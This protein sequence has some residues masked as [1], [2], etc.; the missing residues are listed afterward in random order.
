MK[1][2]LLS[3]AFLLLLLYSSTPIIVEAQ[4]TNTLEW[5]VEVGEEFTYVMQRGYFI[6]PD[7]RIAFSEDN[8]FILSMIVGEKATLRVDGLGEIPTLINDSSQIPQSI[9]NL[10]RSND[11]VPINEDPLDL[12]FVIPIGDWDFLTEMTNLTG[13]QDVTLVDTADEWGTSGVGSFLAPDQSVV[14]ISIDLKYEKE[15]GTL[16]YFRIRYSTLN[17]DLIDIIIVNWHPGMPTTIAGDIQLPT[18]LII[19]IGAVVCFIVSI[20]VYQGY[21]GRKSIAQK[22][23]E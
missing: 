18:I 21:R 13:L 8:P 9:C 11:S 23:G 15:N 10:E 19:S 7:Y 5:G 20:C 6:H 14:T 3:L 4:G 2:K 17:T 1:L 12:Q 22:L 16:N